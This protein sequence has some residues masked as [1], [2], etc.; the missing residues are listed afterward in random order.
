MWMRGD[1]H[2]DQFPHLQRLLQNLV[3][4][5]R[6]DSWMSKPCLIP[7]T[8]SGLPYVDHLDDGLV[9]AAGCNGYAGKS[10]DA[11]GALAAGLITQGRWTDPDLAPSDF[12]VQFAG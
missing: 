3:P 2:L 10:A 11:L 7:R 4:G 12:A 5:L 1:E 9:V 8:P 6:A